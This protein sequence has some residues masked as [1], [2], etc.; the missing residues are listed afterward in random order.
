MQDF[1]GKLA[2]I[3]G[4]ASGVG[5]SLAFALGREGAN[6]LIADVD[7]T[8][9]KKALDGVVESCVNKVGVE[10]NTASKQLLTYVSGLG[11]VLA[12][13][14]VDYRNENGPFKSRAE[15][16]KVPRL[17]AKAFEQAAGFL[18]IRQAKNPLDQFGILKLNHPNE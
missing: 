14:I 10:V 12:Q 7:Q 18:R 16:K 15:L 5:R 13:N 1:S 4:G 2:V 9:L 8:A 3:T 11:P 6:I 17:G